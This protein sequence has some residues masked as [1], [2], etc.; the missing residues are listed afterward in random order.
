MITNLGLAS[1]EGKVEIK[2]CDH[3]T[4]EDVCKYRDQVMAV[5]SELQQKNALILKDT[6]IKLTLCL[7]CSK[8]AP[9][10]II[11]RSV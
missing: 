3:C 8:W 2:N 4:K 7:E 5:M 6:P 11:H 10:Q 1:D 9:V